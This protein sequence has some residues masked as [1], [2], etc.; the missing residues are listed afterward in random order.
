MSCVIE[1]KKAH[2]FSL[3]RDKSGSP[4][5]TT[6]KV[7]TYVTGSSAVN[8]QREERPHEFQLQYQLWRFSCWW[9]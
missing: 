4:T 8:E 7:E 3:F 2:P 6:K 9:S 1:E 5:H